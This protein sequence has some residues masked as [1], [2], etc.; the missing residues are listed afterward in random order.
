[1]V[2]SLVHKLVNAKFEN[3]QAKHRVRG[4]YGERR[5]CNDWEKQVSS[6]S[7]GQFFLKLGA[8]GAVQM[9][10]CVLSL[11]KQN[12]SHADR[13]PDWDSTPIIFRLQY[14]YHWASD[15]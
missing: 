14:R 5:T 4:S 8:E 12:C 1:V 6:E 9:N 10:I 3:L 11:E 2:Q 15:G 7:V 13:R